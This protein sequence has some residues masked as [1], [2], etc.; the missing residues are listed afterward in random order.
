MK[1]SLSALHINFFLLFIPFF[2]CKSKSATVEATPPHVLIYSKTKAFRHECIGP[3]SAALQAYFKEKGITSTF[4][5]DSSVFTPAGLKDFD[6]V[7]F[8]QTTGN[9]L[10]SVQ[11]IAFLDYIRTGK[12]YVGVHAAADTEY[13]WP[14]YGKL[15]GAYFSSHPDIQT[16]ALQKMDTSH[17]SCKHLPDRWTRTDEWYNFKEAPKDVTVLLTIDEFTYQGG[18]LGANHPMAWCHAYDGGRSFYTALG[19]TVESYSDTMFLEHVL[20][21]VI[22]ASGK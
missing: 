3:G 19:H 5:E 1:L 10:D 21:G 22:W 18:T 20:Q 11:Q 13:D 6:V 7:L 9:V 15:V 16:G 14:W 4:S 17:I 8:F 2:G 12:G